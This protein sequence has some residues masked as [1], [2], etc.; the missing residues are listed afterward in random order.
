MQM[1][2]QEVTDPA[3]ME[4]GGRREGLALLGLRTVLEREKVTVRA[5][6]ELIEERLFG[7]PATGSAAGYEIHLGRTEYTPG[8]R[9][10]FRLWR[11]GAIEATEDGA[12]SPN[13]RIVGTSLHGLFDADPFRHALLK[14]LRASLGLAPPATLAGHTAGRERRLDRLADHV[15]RSLDVEQIVGWLR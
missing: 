3:G 11:E 6:A 10:L 13:G 14:A 15:R 4:G 5:R 1:L 2:G 12:Q 9:P 7:Q 8:T